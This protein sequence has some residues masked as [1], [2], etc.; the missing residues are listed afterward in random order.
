MNLINHFAY[1]QRLNFLETG[2]GLKPILNRLGPEFQILPA[3]TIQKL[4]TT[5]RN[6]CNC[7]H[8]SSLLTGIYFSDNLNKDLPHSDIVYSLGFINHFE[9]L[10]LVVKITSSFLSPGGSRRKI[11]IIERCNFQKI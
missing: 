8:F 6:L 11:S 1:R 4:V 9:D 10:P 5:L 7:V 3:L 2:D